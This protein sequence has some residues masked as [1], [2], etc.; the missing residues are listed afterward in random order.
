MPRRW[1]RRLQRSLWTERV[2]EDDPSPV[3]QAGKG[4][5]PERQGLWELVEGVGVVDRVTHLPGW[6]KNLPVAR[7]A[8]VGA[9]GTRR[10]AAATVAQVASPRACRRGR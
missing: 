10:V 1:E 9:A 3:V 4:E 2:P 7:S 6:M 8:E 5:S